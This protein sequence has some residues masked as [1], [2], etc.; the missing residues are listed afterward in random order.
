MEK[1][2]HLLERGRRET[3]AWVLLQ[4]QQQ[5]LPQQQSLPVPQQ[6]QRQQQQ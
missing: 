3:L 6:R 5:L 1:L 4:L 2:Q